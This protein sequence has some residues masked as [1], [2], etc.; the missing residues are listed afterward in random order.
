MYRSTGSLDEEELLCDLLWEE[1]EEREEVDRDE[2]LWA[3][4]DDV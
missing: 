1:P 3:F 2:P 4:V